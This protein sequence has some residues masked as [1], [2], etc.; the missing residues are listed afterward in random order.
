MKAVLLYHFKELKNFNSVSFQTLSTHAAPHSKRWSVFPLP[1]NL[2]CPCVARGRSDAMPIPDL[3][4][5][6]AGSFF[7]W[8]ETS[9]YIRS[10][11]TLKT[12]CCEEAQPSHTKKERNA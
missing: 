7:L 12:L 3:A 8:L 6:R 2:G 10:Q 11:V 5:K 9:L 4:F 1:L